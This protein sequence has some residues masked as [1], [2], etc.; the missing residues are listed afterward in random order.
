M[1]Y[2]I[3]I[4]RKALWF[5]DDGPAIGFDEWKNLVLSDPEMRLDG[6]AE[7]L[8]TQGAKVRIESEGMSVWTAYSKHGRGGNMAC[9]DLKAGNIDVKNPDKEILTKMHQIALK[10]DAKVQGDEGEFYDAKGDR[11]RE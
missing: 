9:F 1:G 2:D 10:L 11:M 4:T 5:E 7:A 6:F 8:T 3:H